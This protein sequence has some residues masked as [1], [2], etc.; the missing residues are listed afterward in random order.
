ML[1][2]TPSWTSDSSS[3]WRLMASR[4]ACFMSLTAAPACA[5]NFLLLH[6]RPSQ[7]RYSG[8]A[9]TARAAAYRSAEPAAARANGLKAGMI[10]ARTAP[11][12]TVTTSRATVSGA[13]LQYLFGSY[14]PLSLVSPKDGVRGRGMGPTYTLS[15]SAS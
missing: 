13:F 15:G 7:K 8:A 2:L 14:P 10:T 5:R 4:T 9:V 12:E 6:P 1:L 11:N 3:R